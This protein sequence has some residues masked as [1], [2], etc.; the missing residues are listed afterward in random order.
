MQWSRRVST[1]TEVRVEGQVSA[2][3]AEG[4][5]E[6]EALVVE[7]RVE[8]QALSTEVRVEERASH[9]CR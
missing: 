4:R 8:G 1:R 5:I 9:E 6:G 7:A 2:A 3:D